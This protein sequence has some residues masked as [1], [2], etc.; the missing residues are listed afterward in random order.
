LEERDED[1]GSGR[2]ALPLTILVALAVSILALGVVE[3]LASRRHSGSTR[4]ENSLAR[5]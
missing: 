1:E 5:T 3:G 2:A 4:L